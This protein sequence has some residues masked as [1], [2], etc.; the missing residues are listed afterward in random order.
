[1]PSKLSEL[2][3]IEDLQRWFTRKIPEVRNL[4][5]WQRLKSLKMYSQQRRMER[6]RIIYTWKIL[7]GLVHNCGLKLTTNERRGREAHIPNLKGKASI[8]RLREQSFQVKGPKLINTLPPSLRKI[9]RVSVDEF[10]H[11]LDKYLEG[12][13]DE[14]IMEGL[15]PAACDQFSAAPSNSIVDQARHVTQQQRR[16]G[17]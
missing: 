11:H 13:P 10:K 5:Y 9:T 6:Y 12:I 14:P 4:N 1:M 2:Q 17:A 16:P 8:K 15:I 3:Q 7:E